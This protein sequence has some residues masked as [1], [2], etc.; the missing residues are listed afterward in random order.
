MHKPGRPE[1]DKLTC[2]AIYVT[3]PSLAFFKLVKMHSIKFKLYWRVLLALSWQWVDSNTPAAMVLYCII[4]EFVRKELKPLARRDFFLGFFVLYHWKTWKILHNTWVYPSWL[5]LLS[6]KKVYLSSLALATSGLKNVSVF[7][8]FLELESYLSRVTIS[9]PLL[10]R[11]P[12]TSQ[13][14]MEV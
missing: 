7:S 6:L 10:L 13:N 4:H 11:T 1:V 14:F 9:W 5:V 8:V 2:T 3:I 12:Q